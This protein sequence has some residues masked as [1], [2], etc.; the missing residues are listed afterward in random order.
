ML[1][2]DSPMS[3]GDGTA[4]LT[5][6]ALIQPIDVFKDAFKASVYDNKNQTIILNSDG[7]RVYFDGEDS[8]FTGYNVFTA[9][10]DAEFKNNVTLDSFRAAST[11]DTAG[12][13][14]IVYKGSTYFVACTALNGG[15]QYLA[16]VPEQYVSANSTGFIGS[17]IS[18]FAF[19][20]A[21]LTIVVVAMT[22]FITVARNRKNQVER[23]Q[24]VNRQLNIA[25]KAAHEAEAVARRAEVVAREAEAKAVNASAAKSD[26]LSNMS[27]DIRTPIN[28][29]IGMLDI[30]DLHRDNHEEVL[31]YLDRIR[32]VTNHLLTLIN[33][34]LDMS[35][36][37]SGKVELSHEAFDM[38]ELLSECI[39][40]TAGQIQGRDLAFHENLDGLEH[41]YLYGSP[42]HLR[43]IFLNIL[44]N[45]V[46]YTN[47]GGH[48][49]FTVDELTS[50]NAGV[51]QI[52]VATADDG[53]GMSKEFQKEIFEPFTRADNT[54][55]SEL[56]GTGLGMAITKNLVDLMGGT[57][58]VESELG[59]G[60]TF[61]VVLPLE[62][63]AAA[64][65][66]AAAGAS[67][68]MA[69]GAA[70]GAGVVAGTGTGMGIAAA[71]AAGIDGSAQTTEPRDISGFK[72]LLVEDNELN[73]EIAKTLLEEK[74]AIITEATNGQE[75][76]DIFSAARPGTFDA[77]LMDVMMP[78][79]DGLDSTRAIRALNRVDAAQI[80]IIAMT[81]NAFAEDVAAAKEAGM[82][83]HLAKPLNFDVVAK[84]LSKYVTRT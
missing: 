52:R 61:T 21:L 31:G 44:G 78:V 76:L 73:R 20:I 9:L 22:F 38:R 55:S 57:I 28:G 58:E 65:V 36:A 69:A 43:R 10:S 2:L 70:A 81:A 71:G 34:V 32:G 62:I 77:I 75:A 83:E 63:N 1:K 41:R 51:A 45:A 80:P 79:M 30:A 46:K 72:L 64:N 54:N 5:H 67:S 39:D 66:A 56:R 49:T 29:I 18:S 4:S 3:Y 50:E 8:L 60:S 82:N 24:E 35:K 6:I 84:T 14:E 40:I 74:G 25:N 7:T 59:A 15:W 12:T 68:G 42:L 33:D 27:H 48:I 23:E 53:I 16:V 11:A 19:F 13:A 47:D 17:V 37:E 26:F